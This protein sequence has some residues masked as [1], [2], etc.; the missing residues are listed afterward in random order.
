MYGVLLA[1]KIKRVV[2]GMM[3]PKPLR[4]GEA[5]VVVSITNAFAPRG[6]R[7]NADPNT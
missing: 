4:M 5:C 1:H 2:S 7:A 6:E 3:E